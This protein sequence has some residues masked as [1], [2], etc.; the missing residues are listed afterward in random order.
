VWFP[1]GFIIFWYAFVI[2]FPSAF[3]GI[4]GYEDF[5]LNAYLWLLLGILF[6]LPDIKLSAEVEAAQL[7]A[8]EPR[9]RWII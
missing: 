1:L 2:L 5:V 6:R 3:A 7:V 9:R 4:Q 8:S